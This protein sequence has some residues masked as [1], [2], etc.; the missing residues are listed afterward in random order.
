VI[1]ITPQGSV[2]LCKTPLEND[3]KNQLT[4]ANATSQQS[5]FN[6]KVV[7]SETDYTYIKKDNTIVIGKPID[8]IISCNYL[9]YKNT[10]F[11]N[12]YYYCF[13]TNMEYVNENATRITIETDVYQT[14]MFDIIKK[15]CFVE[16]EH[17]NDDTIGANT[18]HEGIDT[19]EMIVNEVEYFDELSSGAH[20]IV[21]VS[22]LPEELRTETL[23][24]STRNYNG[25]YSG[26]YYIVCQNYIDASKLIAV[27][28]I[29]DLAE[30]IYD[31]FLVPESLYNTTTW[32]DSFT[33]HLDIFDVDI[34]VSCK[35]LPNT[36][37]STLMATESVDINT[38]LNGYTPKNNKLFTKEFN[39]MYITNNN[40][41]NVEMAYEDFIDNEPTFHIKGSVCP[42]CSIK[43][44]PDNYKKY[45]TSLPQ[46]TDYLYDFGIMG[47]KYP[48]CS[49]SSDSYTNWLTQNAVDY[50]FG[51]VGNVATL[52]VLMATGNPLA[53]GL[54]GIGLIKD[55]LTDKLKHE[56]SPVQAKGN[57][58][59]GDVSFST[60]MT[61][62]TVYQ[63]SLK[64]EFAKRIDDYLS[65]FG[66]KVNE[67][68]IP[69]TEGRT[70]WNYVK[71]IDC[72]FEG[73]IPQMYL[74]KI[75]EIFNNG[76][77]LWHNASTFLDYSQSNTIV[78]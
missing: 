35:L 59:G 28:D 63:M 15:A 2:Y 29:E 39:Y 33:K 23:T 57:I 78:S 45:D 27:M 72:N 67:V 32:S 37:T 16:R 73:D 12:R 47:G 77:T 65:M 50:A 4:F 30:N 31:V 68:K 62:F 14:Y 40:G 58:N 19:G 38:T 20:V 8:D 43:L 55:A 54:S 21:G 69:N 53:L 49:W 48:T 10:G 3:Y 70:N 7:T 26:L 44:I 56:T 76:I 75:K 18:T 42:G 36:T 1:T 64:Y 9:F 34:N 52:G 41:G 17:V 25:I 61:C 11:T 51:E 6:S 46:Y 5:Y 24:I 66:Y 13:I 74:N 22:K 60:S 71:T